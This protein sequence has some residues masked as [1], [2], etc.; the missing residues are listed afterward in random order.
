MT[1]FT[2]PTEACQAQF[3]WTGVQTS[4]PCGFPALEAT[5]LLV[6][7]APASA[8]ASFQGVITGAVL[9]VSNLTAGALGPGSML[10]G[11]GVAAGTEVLAE[12]S[13]SGGNGTYTLNQSQ[14][15]ALEAMTA[16]APTET[17]ALG[18][19]YTVTLDP[20]SSVATIVPVAMPDN[21]P[22]VVTVTRNTPATQSTQFNNL[23]SYQQDALTANFDRAEMGI[24]E[25]K[26]RVTSLE[27]VAFG[28][29]VLPPSFNYGTRTQ[30]S[31]TS[32]ANLPI[33]AADAILNINAATDL[34]PAV[35]AASTRNGAPLT[36]KNL[37][38]SHVQTL[39]RTGADTFDGQVTYP[40]AAGS[41]VTL[42]PYNDGVNTGYAIEG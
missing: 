21:G 27:A 13:G 40:L 1:A 29:P 17:L 34:T 23:D 15:V 5:D 7:Y 18:V 22:G 4:F 41:S 9:T 6:Q 14:N 12:G 25:L 30:R 36:F 8:T 42:V 26:R 33:V 2:V 10:S 32:A 11:T 37:P 16:S 24:A 19:H 35:P 20:L 3:Q 28:A 38:G 39:E 31:I